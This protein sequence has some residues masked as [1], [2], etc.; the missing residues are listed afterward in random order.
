ML[1]R[2]LGELL[3]QRLQCGVGRFVGDAR[4]QTDADIISPAGSCVTFSGR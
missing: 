2:F 3:D 1:R 4:L